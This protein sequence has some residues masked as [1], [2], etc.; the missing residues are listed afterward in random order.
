MKRII[1]LLLTASVAVSLMSVG[2]ISVIA[3]D[4]TGDIIEY[5]NYPQSVVT[6]SAVVSKLNALAKNWMSYGYYLGKGSD[7][8]GQMKSENYMQYADVM[9]DGT[10][11]RAVK[12][13]E[14]RPYGTGRGGESYES[15]QD[16]NGYKAN[17]VYY[18]KYEPV[19]WLILDPASGLVM[20]ES[21]IDSQPYN[22]YVIT[23]GSAKTGYSYWGNTAKSIYANNYYYSSLR[24]WL[25]EDF[26]NTAFNSSQKENI[27]STAIK[28]NASSSKLTKYDA[29]SSN[30][31]IFLLSVTDVKNKAFGFSSDST[32]RAKGTDYAKCQGL[33]VCEDAPDTG[34]SVWRLR[35]GG[36]DSSNNS[37]VSES[38]D[39]DGT[40]VYA[41]DTSAGI[42]PA[43]SLTK[44]KNDSSVVSLGDINSDGSVN[45]A[46]ALLAL[47]SSVGSVKLSSAQF[48]LA[49]VNKDKSV[50][51]SDALL[52]LEY[53]VNRISS[54]K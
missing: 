29:P 53:S 16:D 13:T 6:S 4:K 39:Y 14:Y 5:G 33:W 54:F 27:K 47:Q 9:L 51:S 3:K 1:S 25:N 23:T 8:D 28:N 34:Y 11:Y 7:D 26:Y 41:F 24:K 43:C 21:I 45:S 52:I 17:T 20:C 42:R 44:I 10:R 18:F 30:D 12:F 40:E 38:G 2:F 37:L 15:N 50:N 46:D 48:A 31:K 49:D 32:R 22:S 19:R 35:N 36:T